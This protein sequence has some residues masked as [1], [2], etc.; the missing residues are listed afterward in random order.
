MRCIFVFIRFSVLVEQ[1]A[2]TYVL[3]HLVYE[4]DSVISKVKLNTWFFLPFQIISCFPV[5]IVGTYDMWHYY[6]LHILVLQN[7]VMADNW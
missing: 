6:P 1:D 7:D 5:K 3:C 4:V 2:D